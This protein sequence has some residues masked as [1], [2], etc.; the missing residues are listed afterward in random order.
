[1]ARAS[2]IYLVTNPEEVGEGHVVAA[3]TV[4]HEAEAW[5]KH[6]PEGAFDIMQYRDGPRM[7]EFSDMKLTKF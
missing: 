6:Y 5:L 2:W 3:F 1:M 7:G 4:K